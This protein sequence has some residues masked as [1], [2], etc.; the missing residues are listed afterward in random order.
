MIAVSY[1][2]DLNMGFIRTGKY[3]FIIFFLQLLIFSAG[4]ALAADYTGDFSVLKEAIGNAGSSNSFT[5]NTDLTLD[6][7]IGPPA[8]DG[9]FAEG[10]S[11]SMDAQGLYS[12]F[13]LSSTQSLTLNNFGSRDEFGAIDNSIKNFVGNTSSFIHNSGT[14]EINN[15]IISDN[16]SNYGYGVVYNGDS[17][18]F[19]NVDFVS[20]TSV[21]GPG[22]A[23]YNSGNM[24]IAGGEFTQN[25]AQDA[26]GGA[27]Y[28]TGSIEISGTLFSQNNSKYEGGAISNVGSMTLE[29]VDFV[30]NYTTN[31]AGGAVHNTGVM[32]MSGGSFSQN[33]SKY[34]G[35]AIYSNNSLTLD[36]VDFS[37]NYTTD[38]AGGAIFNNGTAN[39]TGGEF[40]ENQSK[41]E[42][43]A[44][45]NNTSLTLDGVNFEKN[46]STD[47]IGGAIYNNGTAD[48]TGGEFKENQSKYSGGAIFNNNSLTLDSVNFTSNKSL[49][50]IGGAIYNAADMT[51]TGGVFSQNSADTSSA[52]AIFNRGDFSADGTDFSQNQANNDGGALYNINQ[53]TLNNVDFSNNSTK[54]GFGG[55]VYNSG[56]MEVTGGEFT[57]NTSQT[58]NAGAIYNSGTISISDADF[59]QNQSNNDGGAVYS[60]NQVTLNN[61]DFS[62]N[63][64]KYGFGGAVYNSGTME[65]TD[66]KFTQNTSQTS[67]AGAIYNSGTM[68]LTGG[69]FTQNQSN[70]DGGAVYNSNQ[71]TLSNVDFSN[72]S[73]KYGYGGAIYNSD[74]MTVTNSEFTQNTSQ[75]SNAGAVYN[76]GDM[77]LTNAEFTQNQA[78]NDGGAILNSGQLELNNADFSNNS[79]KYGFG[80][81]VYNNATVTLN[82][83]TFLSNS[84]TE[85]KAGAIY[86]SGNAS[87]TNVDFLQNTAKYDGGAIN[88]TNYLTLD[89]VNFLCNSTNSGYGG[90]VYNSGN[91]EMSGGKFESNI[92]ETSNAGAFYNIGIATLSG[93][94]FTGNSANNDGGAIYNTGTLS[95]TNSSFTNNKATNGYGGAIYNTGNLK[96]IADNYQSEFKGNKASNVSDAIYL[97]QDSSLHLSAINGGNITFNDKINSEKLT[98]T[99]DINNPADAASSNYGKV[100]FNDKV[101][102]ATINMHNGTM[103]L[104]VDNLLNDNYLNLYGGS[105]DMINNSVGTAKLNTLVLKSSTITNLGIDVDLANLKSDR[106]SADSVSAEGGVLN[107][108]QVNLLSDSKGKYS[109]VNLADPS[110][111]NSITMSAK[112]ATTDLFKYG[113]VYDP[114]SGNMNF[115]TIGG[116]SYEDYNPKILTPNVSTAVNTYSNQVQIYNEVL[117]RADIF[118][119][120]PHTERVQL[121]YQNMYAYDGDS[122]VFSPIYSRNK[123][124]GIWFKQ[125]STFENIPLN[126]GPTVSN[127]GYGVILGA[128]TEM[129]RLKHGFD[130]YLTA[131]GAY[132]G[133][134]QKFSG[135]NMYQNGGVF[136][137]SGTVY[138]NNFFS[139]LTANVG[140]NAGTAHTSSGEDDFTSL[141]SGTALKL[142]YNFEVP[143]AKLIIQPTYAMSYTFVKTFDYVTSSGVSMTSDPLNTIQLSPGLKFIFNLKHGWQ[144][145]IGANM[146]WNIMDSSKF[147]AN[148]VALPQMS[149]DPYVEYG[150]GVQKRGKA[151]KFAGFFQTMARSGG[152]N[153]VSLQF[154]MRYS[155]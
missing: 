61:V 69:E 20:N 88:N 35:G 56:T 117:R 134:N 62:N 141:V 82:G 8:S 78:N 107:V 122:M 51:V 86:N 28:N 110:I 91:L 84:S 131:Y 112:Y 118:M 138:R 57:Q 137:V 32:E 14:L 37:N 15:S 85:S 93:V 33:H 102:N 53:T 120:L 72:N 17:A 111:K 64:A 10:A 34:E 13:S 143:K 73:T 47:S 42:G 121:K 151:D 114:A 63:S 115:T 41:Y 108:N 43:G 48:I 145:Y 77:T 109:A 149:V 113:V 148:E 99:I 96:L 83:G 38:S 58:S 127:I 29:D 5:A 116:G 132:N 60:S 6:S 150:L 44:I 100:V 105:I 89:R 152:R 106:I 146:V 153:G 155:L 154:G 81:A 52:G 126:N 124:K 9:F 16:I 80:G 11:Y 55:A 71:A 67:N 98:N 21:T 66:G 97:G 45:L 104:G 54:Y 75:T 12:G 18:N 147:Y 130:G 26:A 103:K 4:K 79:A 129:K 39:I 22:G 25:S 30:G 123:N 68:E 119:S 142:G 128:D 133:S 49:V 27:I 50:D 31:S 136:G 74:D 46:S 140:A 65:V 139:T 23:V 24:T 92:S 94:N 1:L 87:I 3:I 95:L 101:S 7:S 59:S 76:S 36:N 125:Y 70:N 40:K 144:P 135:I 19:S 2:D 90:A